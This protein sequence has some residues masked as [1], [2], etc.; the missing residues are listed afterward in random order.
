[1]LVPSAGATFPGANGKI[2]FYSTRDGN[3]E[4]YVMNADGT[5]QT[6]LTNNAFDDGRPAWSPDGTKIAF[7]SY[8]NGDNEIFII[9]AD[10]TGETQITNNTTAHD[11]DPAWSPDGTKI[12]FKSDRDNGS[13]YEIYAMNADGTNQTRLTNNLFWDTSPAWSPDGTKIAFD[14]LRITTGGEI[15]VM[16]VDGSGETR[17][18]N[19]DGAGP[20]WSPDGTKLA[21]HSCRLDGCHET[22]VQYEIFTMN[23]DGS[24]QTQLAGSPTYDVSPAWSPDGTQ[25]AFRSNRD[26]NPEIYRMNANGTSQT[27]L[28]NNTASDNS[29]DWQP[30]PTRGYVRPAGATPLRLSLV[31]TFQPCASP[32][33]AHGSPLAF[34][35]CAP[36][37]PASGHV[38][39]GTASSGFVKIKVLPGAPGP[40]SDTQVEI[41]LNVTDVRCKAGTSTCGNANTTGG[42]DYTGELEGNATIRLTDRNNGTTSSGGTDPATVVDIPMPV[43]AFCANTGSTAVGGTCT[44]SAGPLIPDPCS[45][46]GKRMV[47][48]F[49]DFRVEDGGADGQVATDPNALFLRQGVFVP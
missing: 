19:Q 12:A 5:G 6:R 37:V 3:S 41:T 47:V 30:I 49:S 45:C 38:T 14:S 46:E 4:I 34:G 40:P 13:T 25:M 27:R 42:A 20:D 10:G 39:V 26:G 1:M 18:G 32:N 11:S 29:P 43:N 24:N 16:N 35:S 36:P 21:F 9:N 7:V 31:P 44:V 22:S 17:I 15:Y 23:P 33:R 8:R 2:A 48:G 28:T